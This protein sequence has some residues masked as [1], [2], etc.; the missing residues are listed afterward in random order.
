MEAEQ[1]CLRKMCEDLC[2]HELTISFQ[3]GTMVSHAFVL[4]SKERELADKEKQLAQKSSRSWPLHARWRRCSGQCGWSRRKRYWTSWAR[5]K[6]HWCPSISALSALWGTGMGGEQCATRVAIHKSQDAD[7]RRSH[8]QQLE[9]EWRFLIEK[10]VEHMLMC[11]QS[12]DPNT[13]LEPVVQGPAIDVAEAARISAEGTAKIMAT[14]FHHQLED[15]QG[16][17]S[18]FCICQN[19]LPIV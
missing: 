3:E 12:W 9:A 8:R 15:T 17:H 7:T 6:W 13:S 1:E 18:S 16:S 11:F 5:L 2:N 4:A 10:V 19:L 14:W